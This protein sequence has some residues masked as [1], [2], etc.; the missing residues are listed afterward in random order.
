MIGYSPHYL[1]FGSRSRLLVDFN[2][3]TF[4][5]TEISMRSASA[6]HVD[7][8]VATVHDQLQATL[9]EAQAQSMAEAQQQKQYYNWKIGAVDLKPGDLDLVMLTP[10]RERG[11]LRT[12]RKMRYVRW[13][14]RSWQ[15]SPAMKWQTNVDSHSPSTKTDFFSLHQRLAFPCVWVSTMHGTN[16][17]APPQLSQLPKGVTVGLC[18]E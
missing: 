17:P 18:H 10:L 8:Y 2:F 16:V 5:S 1:M 13:C 15:T 4:R 7:E 6:K 14:I 9:Q 11:R 12:S 3:P